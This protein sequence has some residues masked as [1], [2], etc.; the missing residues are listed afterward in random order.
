VSKVEIH[1]NEKN[2]KEKRKRPLS[3]VSPYSNSANLCVFSAELWVKRSLWYI[4][5]L[6]W[7]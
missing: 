2:L 6:W 1:L 7:L 3:I 4:L 5:F